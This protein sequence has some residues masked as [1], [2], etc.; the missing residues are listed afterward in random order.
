MVGIPESIEMVA[1]A[2]ARPASLD[3]TLQS[4]AAASAQLWQHGGI[5]F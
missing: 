5:E 4:V 1:M 2:R 3:K